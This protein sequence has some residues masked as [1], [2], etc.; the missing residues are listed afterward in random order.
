MQ[1]QEFPLSRF[2]SAQYLGRTKIRFRLPICR[3]L[4][5]GGKFFD[6]VQGKARWKGY[7]HTVLSPLS[8][9]TVLLIAL[10][11]RR[12]CLSGR[13]PCLPSQRHRTPVS[14]TVYH[15]TASGC[16]FWVYISIT[17]QE[18]LE[19]RRC[20]SIKSFNNLQCIQKEKERSI[21]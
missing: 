5:T 17:Y 12:V 3:P 15:D 18:R 1:R 16:A 6:S 7:G 2:N 14:S 13:C 9:S 21:Y 20:H 19:F 10:G 11:E 8:G 4:A